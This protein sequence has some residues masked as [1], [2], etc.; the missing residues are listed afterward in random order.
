VPKEYYTQR[1]STPGTLLITEATLVARRAAGRLNVPGIWSEAQIAGWK[2]IV[3]AVHDQGC[4]IYCQLWHLG[5]A[6]WP[7]ALAA[8]DSDNKLLSAS[9]VPID[10]TRATPEA[11]SEEDIAQC[12]AD[13]TAAAH[14]A[15]HRA[16]FDGVEIHGANGYLPDQFLQDRC[17][18]RTDRWGGTIENRARFPLE[19]AKAVVEAVGSEKTGYRLSPFSDYLGMLMADPYPQF[20]YVTRELKKLNLAY[21]HLIEARISGNDDT[22]TGE[23]HNT[24]FLVKIW[25]NTSP[26]LIAGGFKAESARE[27]VDETYKDFDVAVVFGRYFVS[28]P[29]LVSRVKRGLDLEKYDR[30]SFYTPKV[31]K[32]YIDYPFSRQSVAQT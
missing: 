28:N 6:A 7:E 21:L 20:E 1:A 16:G 11:M 26:V 24:G 14:N 29:D 18:R 22:S 30:A 8:A 10:E 32:G 9:A 27:A 4:F 25:D 5:R 31:S 2:E 13:F 3:D 23:G 15:V 17:N 19:L 12:I